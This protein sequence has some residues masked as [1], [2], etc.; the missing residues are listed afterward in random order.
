MR[1]HTRWAPA[2][3][4][5]PA[6]SLSMCRPSCVR[7]RTWCSHA[8]VA[9]CARP[10]RPGCCAVMSL[11]AAREA[12]SCIDRYVEL[13]RAAADGKEGAVIDERLTAIVERMFSRYGLHTRGDRP[14]IPL[15]LVCSGLPCVPAGASRTASSSRRSASPSR[16]AGWTSW[17]RR[18]TGARTRWPSSPMRCASAR[19]WSSAASSAL[20]SA[21]AV[22]PRAAHAAGSAERPPGLVPVQALLQ[23]LVAERTRCPCRCC[24][25]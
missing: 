23:L 1:S 12:A 14:V 21:A 17:R 7:P 4:L 13:R 6:S 9:S 11:R 25:C 8:P 15:P 16:P 19:T 3:C 5:T 20:R 18:C 2:R 24:G 22:G 10:A